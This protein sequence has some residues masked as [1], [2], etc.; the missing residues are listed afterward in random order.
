MSKA[1]IFIGSIIVIIIIYGIVT[2]AK[3]QTALDI[4]TGIFIL[5]TAYLLIRLGVWIKENG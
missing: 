2:Y 1:L 5:A 4:I 3:Q